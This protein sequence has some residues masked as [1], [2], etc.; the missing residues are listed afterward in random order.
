MRSSNF[1][2]P[3]LA[4]KIDL[5]EHTDKILEQ[6]ISEINPDLVIVQKDVPFKLLNKMRD[7][8]ITVVCGLEDR[9]MKRLARL[10]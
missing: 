6:K 10:T 1:I 4:T 5:E 7:Q 2:I 8:R 3:D 9:K